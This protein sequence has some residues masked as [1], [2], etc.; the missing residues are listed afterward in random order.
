MKKKLYTE[1]KG[2]AWQ[3]EKIVEKLFNECK[4]TNTHWTRSHFAHDDD[5][6]VART[7]VSCTHVE[8]SIKNEKGNKKANENMQNEKKTPSKKGKKVRKKNCQQKQRMKERRIRLYIK[9][10]F[11]GHI[12]IV[13]R[14]SIM[15]ECACT[16][17]CF[18][19][20]FFW[21]WFFTFFL[22]TVGRVDARSAVCFPF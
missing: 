5:V 4:I 11:W 19:V 22:F 13:W 9:K 10:K 2:S 3:I 16:P 20:V 18:L 15:C 1:L 6:M 8:S 7:R 17:M 14:L 21:L 12:E